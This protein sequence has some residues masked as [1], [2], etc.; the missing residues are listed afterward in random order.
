MIFVFLFDLLTMTIDRS[1]HVA[2]NGIITFFFM[3]NFIVY[4]YHI[5][6]H[7]SVDGHLGSC[8]VLPIV[9]STSVHTGV[10]GFRIMVF[11]RYMPR[12]GI[13]VSYVYNSTKL[14]TT[15]MPGVIEWVNKLQHINRI[16]Y[17]A[18][19]TVTVL[20]LHISTGIDPKY[21][22]EWKNKSGCKCCMLYISI[23]LN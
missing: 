21:N 10:H 7:S 2:A 13:A 8:H 17:N 16:E 12:R 9:N 22:A 5:F 11:S 4:R 3:A 23:S 20:Q 18:A 1:I 6:I 15:H 14:E 19:F